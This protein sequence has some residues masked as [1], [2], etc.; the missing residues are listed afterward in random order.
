MDEMVETSR[1][2]AV[3]RLCHRGVDGLG[4]RL[5]VPCIFTRVML[6]AF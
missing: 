6:G 2:S 5:L 1:I 4:K 3:Y